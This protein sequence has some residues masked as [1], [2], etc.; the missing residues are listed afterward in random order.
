[1]LKFDGYGFGGWPVSSEGR[2]IKDILAYTAG[3]MP[4][5]TIKYAMGLGKPDG[6]M[7]CVKMGYNLFD[8][9][10]PTREARHHR[11]YVFT[12]D[13]VNYNPFYEFIYILDDKYRTD[14]KSISEDCD[15][16][17]CKNYSK[18]FI[19]HLFK[20]GDTLAYRLATI[21]NLRFYSILMEKI[22]C[23]NGR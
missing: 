19:R 4:D 8:C 17:T 5:D 3:L 11:L 14:E 23:H 18:A 20:A 13:D 16:Y 9:V 10:I 7:Q 22:R 12:D 2:L 15:C 6:I 1:M 21:H